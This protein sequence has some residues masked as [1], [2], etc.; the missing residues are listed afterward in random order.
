MAGSTTSSCRFY[1]WNIFL[2]H[3]GIPLK[4]FCI[5]T[6]SV[7]SMDL[8]DE[9]EDFKIPPSVEGQKRCVVNTLKPESMTAPANPPSHS[10]ATELIVFLYISDGFCNWFVLYQAFPNTSKK[11]Q[12]KLASSL[13]RHFPLLEKGG[14]RERLSWTYGKKIKSFKAWEISQSL[15]WLPCR[16]K[17]QSLIPRTQFCF[18]FK[19][20]MVVPACNLSA[21]EVESSRLP[22]LPGPPV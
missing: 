10:W 20:N 1:S 11:G 3:P 21:G 12:K 13:V 9:G 2:W 5:C 6:L 18:V 7:R 16:K 4:W 22:G 19:L 17:E 15:N 14:A 8:D